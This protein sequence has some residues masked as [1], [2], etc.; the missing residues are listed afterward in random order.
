MVRYVEFYSMPAKTYLTYPTAVVMQALASG[1]HYGFDIMD[2]TGLPSGTVYPML[3]RLERMRL[4]RSKWEDETAAR[5]E[6]R[7]QRRYYEITGA[8][9]QV[10]AELAGRYR[11]LERL[12]PR[13]PRRR[14][15]APERG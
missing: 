15:L 4:V 14:K 7:P 2:I 5:N 12:L 9:E 13:A 6:S 3:R 10:L 8:G 1:Y 11:L